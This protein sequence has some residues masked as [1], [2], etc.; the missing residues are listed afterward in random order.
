MRIDIG[1]L[2]RSFTWAARGFCMGLR[3]RNFRIH[4]TAAFYVT[5]AGYLADFSRG[6]L[7]VLCLCFALVMTMELVNTAVETLCD[8]VTSKRDAMIRD[9][10]DIAA[11]AVLTAALFSIAVGLIL[12]A[13]PTSIHAILDK[14]QQYIWIDVA[15]AASVPVSIAFIFAVEQ[16]GEHK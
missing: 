1:G 2:A 10:K 15:L 14:L 11:G 4:L 6:E 8:R 9:A 16:K 12:F 5:A 3:E 7:A 13:N